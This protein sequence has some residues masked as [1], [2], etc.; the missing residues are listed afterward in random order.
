MRIISAKDYG[1]RKV[2]KV[3]ANPDHPQWVHEHT[4]G[5]GIAR[6]GL[7][8]FAAAPPQHTGDTAEAATM[9]VEPC[10]ECRYNWRTYQR[11]YRG[12]DPRTSDELSTELQAYVEEQEAPVPS[13]IPELVGR[14][15]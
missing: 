4:A 5:E 6:R 11:I 13:D 3:A 10:H 9:G 15:L 2:F 7:G 14:N 1:F 8:T 12:D